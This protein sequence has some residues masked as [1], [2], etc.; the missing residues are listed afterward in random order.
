MSFIVRQP[1]GGG[2]MHVYVAESHHISE[3]GQSRQSR[4]YLG[5]LAPDGVE[6]LL[7]AR[8]P[9]PAPATLAMLERDGIKYA[10]RRAGKPGPK[11]ARAQSAM[12][13]AVVL[14]VG[15]TEALYMMAA[16]SGLSSALAG[17]FGAMDGARLLGL[18]M[19]QACE[20][21]PS[22]LAGEWLADTPHGERCGAVSASTHDR[23]LAGVGS[24]GK[25][26]SE[27]FRL[28]IE[29]CGKPRA[30]IHDTTSIS[31]YAEGLSQAEWGYNRDKEDLR[32][33]NIA[34][35]CSRDGR[36]PLWF[37]TIPG[38]VPDVST[39]RTTCGMISELGIAGFTMSLDRGYFS[40]ANL[41]GM[42]DAE[43]GFVIGAPLSRA[44]AAALVNERR[45]DL[46]SSKHSF[47]HEGT[48]LRHVACDYLVE[49]PNGR[50]RRLPAHLYLDTERREA[51]ARRLETS[52][53]E[54]EAKA[55]ARSAVKPFKSFS[56]AAKWIDDNAGHLG[57]CLAPCVR[58]RKVAVRRMDDAVAESC[59]SFGFTLL[60]ATD[61]KSGRD[62]V[63]SDY[64]CRDVA[65]KIFDT[66]KNGTGNNRLRSG[67][68]NAAEGRVFVAFLATILHGLAERRLAKAGAKTRSTR[69]AFEL[70]AK[71][72]TVRQPN[73]R[74]LQLEVPRKAQDI[75]KILTESNL[76]KSKGV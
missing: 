47:L 75:F 35:V 23:L 56:D 62:A 65:E 48:R 66:Y 36:I 49:L 45:K 12:H 54:L 18:A 60:V 59:G 69:E 55:A 58:K 61:R 67:G 17:A 42:L 71:I 19:H 73:G 64:R 51:L 57:K 32:Q 22:Y 29:A 4:V 70:L 74:T 43:L 10:G 16:Q 24:D 26:R 27:F 5:V 3:L 20:S 68:D 7:G 13:G 6:L 28:W 53:L 40:E 44:Q 39:L 72:K 63:L 33:V 14:E 76:A 15:R 2:R 38:S 21:G 41:A 31:T 34:L 1:K 8:T 9:E 50:T 30:L 52:V 46:E 25:A 11:P 37:R